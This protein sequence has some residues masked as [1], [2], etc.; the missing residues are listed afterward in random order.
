MVQIKKVI[1]NYSRLKGNV[2]IDGA[3]N[4]IL[5]IVAASILING[6]VCINNV[7]NIKDLDVMLNI[8][9]SIGVKSLKQ[10]NTLYI[11]N[12]G[13]YE[14]D[15]LSDDVKKIRGSYYFMGSL[16]S[17]LKKVRINHPGGCQ[18]GDRLI[19]MHINGFKTLGANVSED[20][21]INIYGNLIGDSIYLEKYSV[22]ATINLILAATNANGITRIYNP[23]LEPEVDDVINFLYT[24]G[25]NIRRYN[26]YIEIYG[27]DTIICDFTYS[28]IPDRIEAL[29]YVI[30]GLINGNLAIH[31]VNIN[32]IV[33]PIKMLI[34]HGA[35]IKIKGNS[36]IVKKSVIKKMDIVCDRYPFVPT[37]INSMMVLLLIMN[38]GGSI[39]DM[40]FDNRFRSA[41]ELRSMGACIELSDKLYIK[42]SKLKCGYVIGSDLR[43]TAML[44]FAGLCVKGSTI[45]D[46]IYYME[47]GYSNY[48]EKIKGIKGKIME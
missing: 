18:I 4:S 1:T 19:D 33:Y 28:I 48:I 14:C 11:I 8:L 31:N 24:A 5:P 25:Y 37:D 3:K 30:L 47:R 21:Y 38:N 44:V 43:G 6:T 23:A 34:D 35:N 20:K 10:N 7:P 27:M 32:H 36:L 40:I 9:N 41:L 22:G 46:N 2:Y 26:E 15:L 13:V 12:N 29:S 45:I 39:K 16:L 42:P 17:R